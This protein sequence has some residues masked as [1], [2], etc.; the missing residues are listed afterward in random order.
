MTRRSFIAAAAAASA[1]NAATPKYGLGIVV[2][3]FNYRRS[4]TALE[5]LEYCHSLGAA[6]V[7]VPLTVKQPEELKTIRDK[8]GEWGMYVEGM[9]R[10]PKTEDTSQLEKT[11]REASEVG[12]SCVRSVCLSGR[13]YET[14]DSLSDW[15]DFVTVSKAALARAI[16][17]CEK[18]KIGLALENHKDWTL[19]EHL[20][21]LKEYESEYFGVNLD[22]GNNA[23]LLDE[24][25]EH[26]EA[27]AP[28]TIATH[29]KDMGVEEYEDGFLLSEVPFGQ[30]I[31]DMPRLAAILREKRP[32][33]KL[34]LEMITRNPLK[35]TCL[36]KKYWETM[37]DRSGS[38]LAN[39]LSV[40]RKN[41]PE[42]P[43]PRM[44]GLDQA[45]KVRL[46]ENNVK[47]CLEFA[48]AKMG[49]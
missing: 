9:A 49:L 32:K 44:D 29:A 23:S 10:L 35:I 45:A 26:A 43:M 30:G 33:T 18:H 37:P 11:L 46:E 8:A 5:F 48:K 47:L 12:V 34:S 4:R 31:L 22:T 36:T 21:L 25:M 42:K 1:L 3:S 39:M 2:H 27:L 15:R 16:P 20:K 28:Y 41:K 6:G 38:Y 13:R 19:E 14:F 17:I 40:V 24:P 7:Q